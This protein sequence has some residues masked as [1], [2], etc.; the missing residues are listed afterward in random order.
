MD[1]RLQAPLLSPAL[2]GGF[3]TTSAAWA[4]PALGDSAVTESPRRKEGSGS[5]MK[6]FLSPSHAVQRQGC[7]G[8]VDS[9]EERQSRD[10]YG[11]WGPD[12][13][14]GV[15]ARKVS[16]FS[17]SEALP[18]ALGQSP[19][20]AS[21]EGG[22]PGSRIPRERQL[23]PLGARAWSEREAGQE[24][25]PLLAGKPEGGMRGAQGT[26]LPPLLSPRAPG[27]AELQAD[28]GLHVSPGCCVLGRWGCR[29]ISGG[30]G[31]C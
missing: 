29:A 19:P 14:S 21:P 4:S 10:Q 15:G 31:R 22:V 20:K 11:P 3:F 18:R 17:A 25:G 24:Q 26:G 13:V 9:R 12:N 23:F 16:G 8:W 6:E 7:P 5:H 1:C 28:G 30:L 27:A 2:A